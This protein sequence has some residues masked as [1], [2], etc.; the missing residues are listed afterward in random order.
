MITGVFLREDGSWGKGKR[1]PPVV[2]VVAQIVAG[3]EH[4]LPLADVAEPPPAEVRRVIDR[5]RHRRL[6]ELG[7][8]HPLQERAPLLT[9]RGGTVD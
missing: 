9:T 7:L 4:R 3:V 1:A 8:D 2:R 6:A 5:R